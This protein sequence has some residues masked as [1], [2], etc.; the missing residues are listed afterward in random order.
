MTVMQE[1]VCGWRWFSDMVG[2]WKYA[3]KAVTESEKG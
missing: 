2:S 1:G 3:K